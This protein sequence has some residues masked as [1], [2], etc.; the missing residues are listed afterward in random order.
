MIKVSSDQGALRGVAGREHKVRS[1]VDRGRQDEPVVVVHMFPK[2]VDPPGGTRNIRQCAPKFILK[3]V[4][5]LSNK[6]GI[7]MRIVQEF[8]KVDDT[9]LM[10]IN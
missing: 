7:H 6:F 8:A 9:G 10:L 3:D 2:K 1:P 4:L 5:D